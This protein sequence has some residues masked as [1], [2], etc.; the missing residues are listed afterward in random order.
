MA[1]E[2]A[3]NPQKSNQDIIKLYHQ[4]E[5]IK[6]EVHE[7][8]AKNREAKEENRALFAEIGEFASGICEERAKRRVLENPSNSIQDNEAKGKNRE[9]KAEIW[10]FFTEV[11]GT[12]FEVISAHKE[13]NDKL[14]ICKEAET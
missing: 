10:T 1:E 8:K 13:L 12:F 9:A 7:A 14:K 11:E 2:E 5:A 6:Q 3:Y 4:A